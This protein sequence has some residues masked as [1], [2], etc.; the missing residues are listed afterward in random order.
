MYPQLKTLRV[1]QVT[2]DTFVQVVSLAFRVALALISGIAVLSF[3]ECL[4]WQF[5]YLESNHAAVVRILNMI[6]M[7]T[8]V[9]NGLFNDYVRQGIVRHSKRII[10]PLQVYGDGRYKSL[11]DHE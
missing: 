3:S 11:F 4:R 5:R 6:T 2:R 10:S 9:D 7:S 1:S 8:T